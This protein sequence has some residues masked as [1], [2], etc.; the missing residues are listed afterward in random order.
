MRDALLVQNR[1]ILYSL[2]EWGQ[3]EVWSWGNETGSSWRMSGDITPTWSRIVYILN[4][5]SF[6]LNSVDF[7]GHNDA[8]MLEVG[9]G[10]L[11][12]EENRSHFAFWAAMKS[13]LII[14][15]ALDELSTELVD[16]LKNK[17]LLAFSQD[18]V[19]GKPAAPYKWGINPDWTWNS[20]NPAEYWSGESGNG[21][22][23]LAFNPLGMEE[24]KEIL[25]SEVPQLAGGGGGFEVTDIWTGE[26]LGC[27]VR[28]I[29]RTVASHDTAGFMVG[30]GCGQTPS[31]T[32]QSPQKTSGARK[33]R[34][35]FGKSM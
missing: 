21:T 24:M 32:A 15:T 19:F 17:Y 33:R 22:L 12:L 27:V 29:N 9:N 25:W 23:V 11:T 20:T 26:V 13:P 8:D 5:N 6:L 2:C 28:G 34:N 35:L 1:T 18:E 3:A 14:G 31:G 7:W 10:N 16:V 4:D 30:R